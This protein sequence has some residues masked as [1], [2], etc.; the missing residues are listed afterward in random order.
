M[1]SR[2]AFSVVLP[3]YNAQTWIGRAVQSALRQQG[4]GEIEVVIVDDRSTDG[5]LDAAHALA[6]ADPRIRVL[7][8]AANLGPGGTRNA[9]LAAAN[10]EWIALLDADDAFAD[11]RLSRLAAIAAESSAPIVADLPILFDLG[12]NV[13]AP[14]QLATSGGWRLLKPTDLLK[15]DP[16]SGLDL[17]L[18]KPIF[19]RNLVESGQWRYGDIRH[20][21]DF[22]LYLDLLTA[23]Q[24]FALLHEA[25]YIF[26][27][28]VGEVSGRFSPGS[29]TDVDYRAIAS[30]S[31]GLAAHY[32]DG[33]E[34]A[35][36]AR[37]LNEKAER[38]LDANRAYGWTVLRKGEW[39]RLRRWLASDP[40]N[41]GELAG[42]ALRKLGGHR[43]R[44]ERAR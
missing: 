22:T 42:I 15:P 27:A 11:G 17:G 43:G 2:P 36:I 10:G 35:E 28:R 41:A 20:G 40:A 33:P 38:A 6:A 1:P 5:S 23:G 24:S 19:H 9:G 13:E 4:V 30:G 26:S 21:E 14:T 31:R 29:V 7:Q 34:G 18:L 37:L 8:N 3:C 25:H 12:A 32:A 39:K 16:I 44:V